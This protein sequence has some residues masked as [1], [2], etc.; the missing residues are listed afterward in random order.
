M[1]HENHFA[2]IFGFIGSS[3]SR[4]SHHVKYNNKIIAN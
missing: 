1:L 3:L 2:P 4:L